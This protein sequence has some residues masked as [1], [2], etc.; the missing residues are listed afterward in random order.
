MLLWGLASLNFE[1]EAGRLET[2]GRVDLQLSCEGHWRQNPPFLKHF[3]LF[4][5]KTLSDWMIIL[6]FTLGRVSAFS[7]F[8]DFGVNHI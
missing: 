4:L 3:S 2:Q 5:L 7:K 1:E 8:T 6:G